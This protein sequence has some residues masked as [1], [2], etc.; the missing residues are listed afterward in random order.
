VFSS[1]HSPPSMTSPLSLT[2]MRSEDLIK[3]KA[4]PNGLTQNVVG[5]TGSYMVLVSRMPVMCSTY[6]Q[7]DVTSHTFVKAIFAKDAEGSRKSA[8]QICALFVRIV[9]LWRLGEFKHL[10]LSIFLVQTRLV[11]GNRVGLGLVA[12]LGLNCRRR[13]HVCDS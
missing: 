9:K 10:R 3:L 4:T 2:R 13:R 6:P 5:S 8:L 11:R 7:R 1:R 12:C